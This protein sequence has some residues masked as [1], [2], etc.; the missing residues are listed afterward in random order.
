MGDNGGT[1]S[2]QPRV[3]Q[4]VLLAAVDSGYFESPSREDV[5]EIAGEC[6][7]AE[8]EAKRRL[9]RG[10][11]VVLQEYRD[12]DESTDGLL[13]DPTTRRI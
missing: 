4:E 12:D 7:L 3:D 9:A 8:Q 5:A 13:T 1:G 6:G 10:L 2:S 11:A